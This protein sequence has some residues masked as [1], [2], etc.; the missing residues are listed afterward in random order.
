VHRIA[1]VAVASDRG[2]G[3]TGTGSLTFIAMGRL[4]QYGLE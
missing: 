4:P 1:P 2:P 3:D